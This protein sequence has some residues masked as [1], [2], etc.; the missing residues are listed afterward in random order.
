MG[1]P[2]IIRGNVDDS[3]ILDSTSGNLMVSNGTNFVTATMSGDATIASDRDWET[4][5]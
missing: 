1:I 4:H 2:S 5:S 3:D